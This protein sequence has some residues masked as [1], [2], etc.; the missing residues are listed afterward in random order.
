MANFSETVPDSTEMSRLTKSGPRRPHDAGTAGIETVFF[1]LV[2]AGRVF[3]P[4]FGFAPGC[5]S[6]FASAL[7]TG[8]V[9]PWLPYQIFGSA[10]IGMLAG[11]LPPLR[12]K[13]E[14]AC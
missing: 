3:G 6:L 4:G 11:L 7:L 10:W 13:A 14:I 9:G 12:G 1:L 8:A 5:T 2:L